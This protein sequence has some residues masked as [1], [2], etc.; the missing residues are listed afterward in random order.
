MIQ[1]FRKTIKGKKLQELK[2]LK[3]GSWI[4]VSDATTEEIKMVADLADLE[5]ADVDDVMDDYELPRIEGHEKS[6]VLFVRSPAPNNRLMETDVLM[7]VLTEKYLVT[8][9]TRKNP[10]IKRIFK[11]K[12][13]PPTTQQAWFLGHL[14]LKITQA[15]TE[16]IKQLSDESMQKRRELDNVKSDDIVQLTENGAI[17]NQY[18]SA[19]E[20]MESVYEVLLKGKLI[21]LNEDEYD[22]FEDLL[23]STNQSIDVCTDRIR[24]ISSLRDTY[25]IIFTNDLNKTIKF[26]TSFTILLT[27]PTIVAS[28]YGMN[29]SLP[30]E[31]HPLAFWLLMMMVGVI[32]LILLIWF[33]KK[34][35]F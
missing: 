27:I 25:Q 31:N 9:S 32:V 7:I 24:G 13:L 14:L 16:K 26:L 3:S 33:R 6:V 8:I 2:E 34:K 12:K 20:P 15:Y 19:L 11:S 23:N 21:P 10:Y 5:W 4:D 35:W 1:I 17:L 30:L 22:I 29:I 28:V 18:L